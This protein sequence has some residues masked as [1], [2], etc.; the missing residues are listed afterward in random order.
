[1]LPQELLAPFPFWRCTAWGSNVLPFSHHRKELITVNHSPRALWLSSVKCRALSIPGTAIAQGPPPGSPGSGLI[2]LNPLST[3]NYRPFPPFSDLHNEGT[4]HFPFQGPKCLIVSLTFV[5]RKANCT[6]TWVTPVIF[7][8]AWVPT[9]SRVYDKAS[10]V[11]TYWCHGAGVKGRG[12][13]KEK[14]GDPI[15]VG[16]W[17]R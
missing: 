4:N 7:I 1:M 15:Q 14:E 8:F 3:R 6:C 12:S 5:S 13:G 2:L 11:R 17:Y 9:E 16:P 10:C